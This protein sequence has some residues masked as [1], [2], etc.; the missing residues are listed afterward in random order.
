MKAPPFSRNKLIQ[1]QQ[2]IKTTYGRPDH[3]LK[4]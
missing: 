4:S 1:Q 2:K 3:I